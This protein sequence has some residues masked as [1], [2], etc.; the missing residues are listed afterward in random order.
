MY[1]CQL[2]NVFEIRRNTAIW[3]KRWT[4]ICYSTIAV[5][6]FDHFGYRLVGLVLDGACLVLK[7]ASGCDFTSYWWLVLGNFWEWGWCVIRLDHSNM[8]IHSHKRLGHSRVCC[9]QSQSL[10]C[11]WPVYGLCS[12]I[13]H[14]YCR[15][16]EGTGYRMVFPNYKVVGKP[17]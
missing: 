5:T 13:F 11:K 14:S 4:I 7:T 3:S 9:W 15:L 16:P 8:S 1:V 17:P 6:Q 12:F 2:S 10:I